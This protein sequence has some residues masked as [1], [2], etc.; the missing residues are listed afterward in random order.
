MTHHDCV[1]A[2]E[3]LN[4]PVARIAKQDTGCLSTRSVWNV[5]TSSC[6]NSSMQKMSCVISH[7]KA[8]KLLV[9]RFWAEIRVSTLV[10]SQA[11]LLS[12]ARKSLTSIMP[13]TDCSFGHESTNGFSQALDSHGPSSILSHRHHT[14]TTIS[15]TTEVHACQAHG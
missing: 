15:K 5:I 2:N 10:G 12:E 1:A 8:Y 14:E 9:L 13:A 3:N 7:R 6:S 11:P 4:L